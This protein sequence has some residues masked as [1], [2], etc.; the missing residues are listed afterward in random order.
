MRPSFTWRHITAGDSCLLEAKA[1][2]QEVL[3]G[4]KLTVQ[5]KLEDLQEGMEFTGTVNKV[6]MLHGVVIDIGAEFDGWAPSTSTP[7]FFVM[8]DLPYHPPLDWGG[9]FLSPAGY[10]K[11][12][13][14]VC[15]GV[16]LV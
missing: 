16:C 3:N 7:D 5:V 2:Y 15:M 13:D 4:E 12:A 6:L 8:A 1:V 9:V 11:V 14:V 10:I